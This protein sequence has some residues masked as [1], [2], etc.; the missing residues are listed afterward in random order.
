MVFNIETLS[1]N[2][3]DL[4]IKASGNPMRTSIQTN[5][6]C[7]EKDYKRGLT[8]SKTNIGEGHDQF[9]TGIN[10]T[11]N[12]HAPL[13]MWKEIQRYHFLDFISSQST[14]HCIQKFDLNTQCNEYVWKDT[15]DKLNKCVESLN[16][17]FD[18]ELWYEMI[19][20]V[21]CGFLLGATMTTNYRQLKTIYKQRKNHKLFEWHEFCKW[22]E[23][24]PHSELITGENKDE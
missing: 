16:T 7:T 19:S 13:Y 12:I 1:V 2:N 24:L 6:V 23:S 10:V 8:L 18:K 11:F 4:A 15:I 5:D 17:K 20:N 14:M 21:P 3:L 9:L 22:I